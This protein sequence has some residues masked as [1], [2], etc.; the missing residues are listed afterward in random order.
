MLKHRF[1]TVFFTFLVFLN[2]LCLLENQI[3]AESN[4][5]IPHSV[6]CLVS[7]ENSFLSQGYQGHKEIHFPKIAKAAARAY[8]AGTLQV[9][10]PPIEH[11]RSS[12]IT[13]ALP[14]APIYQ[15]KAV[16]RI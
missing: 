11:L 13:S 12:S 10:S 3:P 2:A 8:P 16:Y 9:G 7:Q 14:S 15:L 6:S 5:Q 1:L 4:G